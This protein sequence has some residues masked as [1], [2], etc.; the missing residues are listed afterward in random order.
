MGEFVTGST[1]KARKEH[2]CEWCGQAILVGE[3]HELNEGR[4]EGGWFRARLH[5]ECQN[6]WNEWTR[7]WGDDCE[8]DAHQMQR[9][10]AEEREEGADWGAI[11]NGMSNA[12][13]KDRGESENAAAK[14]E[15][16]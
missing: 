7:R 9:G 6:A 14:N 5:I 12:L 10:K 1:P 15:G 13:E 3:K 16:G 11:L 4:R 8:F 2:R